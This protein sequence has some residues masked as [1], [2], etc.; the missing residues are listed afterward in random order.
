MKETTHTPERE[1]ESFTPAVSLAMYQ[2]LK[3]TLD[4]W[5]TTGFSDC[6]EDCHCVVQTV[7]HALAR[8]EGREP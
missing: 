5:D 7:Q 4:Y 3:E 1:P 6:D 2:A 8:A